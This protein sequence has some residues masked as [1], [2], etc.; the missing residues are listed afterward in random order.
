MILLI[1]N[2][3]RDLDLGE[4][5]MQ[6]YIGERLK[7][8][9]DVD[10]RIIHYSE[11]DGETLKKSPE[12]KAV[13]IG[14]SRDPWEYVNLHNIYGGEM[15]LIKNTSVPVLGICAGMQIMAIAYGVGLKRLCIGMEERGYTR[16]RKIG[17]SSVLEGLSDEITMWEFHDLMLASVPEGFENV[18]NSDS[19]IQMI[20]RKEGTP[21]FGVQFHPERFDDKHP[22]G[23]KLLENF[24]N[25]TMC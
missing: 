7:T 13:I 24:V 3:I 22:E 6:H 25:L 23:K 4:L 19:G 21:T 10:Y 8:N 17:N 1:N 12:I 14:G 9:F 15:E 18:V 5:E 2:Y 16:L 20:Q 11:V